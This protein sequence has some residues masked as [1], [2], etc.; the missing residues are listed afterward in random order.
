MKLL[1]LIV[2]VFPFMVD[3]QNTDSSWIVKNYIKKEQYIT[4]R[5]GVRLFTSIYIPRDTSEKHPVLIKRTPYSCS[6]YGDSI[7]FPF[8]DN[9]YKTYLKENYIMVIQDVRGKFMSEGMFMD[10]RPFN[11]DKKTNKDTDEASD[12]YDTVDWLMKNIDNNNGKA[13]VFGISYP[14][15]YA[16]Q[17]ALSNHAAIVAVSPQAPV[18]DWFIGDDFHHNGAFMLMDAFN[19]YVVR[20]FGAPRTEPHTTGFKTAYTPSTKDSYSFF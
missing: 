6:P 14:G 12:T 5:D 7:Y 1:L 13:G 18:T 2:L 16:V 3:A 20:G 9:H 17:A 19:F 11:P 8:W 10:V 15:Y 4:M